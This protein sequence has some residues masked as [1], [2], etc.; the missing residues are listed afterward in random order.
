MPPTSRDARDGLI[1]KCCAFI[2]KGL[3]IGTGADENQLMRDVRDAHRRRRLTACR[4][5]ASQ[6]VHHR[7]GFVL[8]PVSRQQVIN[9]HQALKVAAAAAYRE[10]PNSMIFERRGQNARVAASLADVVAHMM[11]AAWD[12]N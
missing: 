3:A 2:N 12:E 9:E 10:V 4:R 1:Q 11:T 7:A 5:R 6:P 8:S